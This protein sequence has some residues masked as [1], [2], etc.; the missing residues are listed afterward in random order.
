ME[1]TEENSE[2]ITTAPFGIFK[3]FLHQWLQIF[4]ATKW[5]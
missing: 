5:N 4:A 3:L 2:M 1:N